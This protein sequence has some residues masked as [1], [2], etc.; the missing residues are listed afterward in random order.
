STRLQSSLLDGYLLAPGQPTRV[1]VKLGATDTAPF[2]GTVEFFLKNGYAKSVRAIAPVVP[3]RLEVAVADS[4]S[5]EII[6]FGKVEAGRY[7]ER[8]ITVTNRGGV[9][10][11]LEFHV[12]EPF[13]LLT[14]PGP[15]LGP[16]SSVNLSIGL[17]PIASRR[18]PVDVTMG[19]SGNDQTLSIRLLGN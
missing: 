10:V 16:L 15:Q 11:P 8:G 4:L 13:R 1:T 9:G 18:G 2:D 17:F 19:V 12:P 14:N 6:N 7:V 3:S 5:T